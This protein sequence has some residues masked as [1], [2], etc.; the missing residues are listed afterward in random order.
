MQ[1]SLV[2]SANLFR[3]VHFFDILAA[4]VFAVSGTLVASRKGMDVMGFMWFAVITGVATQ[5]PWLVRGVDPT[6]K[7]ARLANY[8]LTLRRDV[9]ALSHACGAPHPSLITADQLELLDDRFGAK[10]V[11]E[12]F[13]YGRGFGLPSSTDCDEVRRLMSV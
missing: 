1:T 6:L 11:A 12:L 4:V 3:L 10:T 7:A 9:L 5:H 2:D 8:I 13:G